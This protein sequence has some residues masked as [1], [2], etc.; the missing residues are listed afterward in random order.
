M[1][2]LFAAHE[3]LFIEELSKLRRL[4]LNL[5]MAQTFRRKQVN[6]IVQEHPCV[7]EKLL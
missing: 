4:L 7:D 1:Y 3:Y 2:V 6:R 5:V